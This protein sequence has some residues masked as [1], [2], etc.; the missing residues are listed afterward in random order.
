[1]KDESLSARFARIRKHYDME[2]PRMFAEH[3]RTGRVH[4]DPYRLDFTSDM[5]PIEA[6]VWSDIRCAAL[7]FFPQL[8]VLSYFLDFAD[9]F[10]KIAIECDG[11]QWHDAEKDA[12]RDARLADIG[13]TVY[14]ITGSMCKRT[15]RRP[16]DLLLEHEQNGYSEEE[17]LRLTR[18]HAAAWFAST[19]EGVVEAI[20]ITHYGFSDP[21]AAAGLYVRPAL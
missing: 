7:P 14:R 11:K 4:F 16:V 18:P 17:A 5:T 2:L 8:P 13:W 6:A 19:S 12:H 3:D 21:F 10:K 9:P 1:M 20:G 15:M